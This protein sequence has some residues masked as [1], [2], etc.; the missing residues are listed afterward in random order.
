MSIDTYI[1]DIAWVDRMLM[2]LEPNSEDE[3]IWRASY[4]EEMITD[5]LDKARNIVEVAVHE[6]TQLPA[7]PAGLGQEISPT[8]PYYQPTLPAPLAEEDASMPPAGDPST[9]STGGDVG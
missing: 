7:L 2:Q 1:K 4:S 9:L 5:L 3:A 6:S 8:A